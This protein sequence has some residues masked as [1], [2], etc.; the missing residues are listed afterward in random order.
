M[1]ACRDR[2]GL[3]EMY[4]VS[5]GLVKL[6]HVVASPVA[7]ARCKALG[8]YCFSRL[9]HAC[10]KAWHFGE[11]GLESTLSAFSHALQT[12]TTA[13]RSVSRRTRFAKH[14]LAK[15]NQSKECD[16][17][18][19]LR[20]ALERASERARERERERERQRERESRSL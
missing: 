2:E 3:E 6:M 4:V 12:H 1:H 11:F 7:H 15:L 19:V 20:G 8:L 9:A 13:Y 16:T 17:K 10:C 14:A 5:H 18:E